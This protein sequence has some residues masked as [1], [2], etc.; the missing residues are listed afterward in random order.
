MEGAPLGNPCGRLH[1]PRLSKDGSPK[2][3]KAMTT[4]AELWKAVTD[5]PSGVVV[6]CRRLAQVQGSGR[7]RARLAQLA[8]YA[9]LVAE[10][11][12]RGAAGPIACHARLDGM[13]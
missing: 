10:C 9:E 2:E 12:A 5:D 13:E 3:G 11:G 8:K 4:R 6:E 7:V 1:C